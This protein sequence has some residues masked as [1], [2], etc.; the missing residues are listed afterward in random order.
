MNKL[1]ELFLKLKDFQCYK[2]M[3]IDICRIGL[4]AVVF[5]L[6]FLL[7]GV[8]RNCAVKILRKLTAK[9]SFSFD[10]DIV[11]ELKAPFDLLFFFL[12]LMIK[13][14]KKRLNSVN[15]TF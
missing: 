4:A 5:M 6:L 1:T 7:R 15:S 13:C 11:R 3:G 10:E 12:S 2:F 14:Y 9:V 8:I